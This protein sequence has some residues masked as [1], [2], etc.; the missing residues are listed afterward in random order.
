MENNPQPQFSARY[1]PLKSPVWQACRRD[2]TEPWRSL[3]EKWH[4]KASFCCCSVCRDRRQ[5]WTTSVS[6]LPCVTARPAYLF[7]ESCCLQAVF[8]IC[9]LILEPLPQRLEFVSLFLDVLLMCRVLL[10]QIPPPPHNICANGPM[11]VAFCFESLAE[12]WKKHEHN[13]LTAS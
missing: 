3:F 11:R 5:K 1:K 9:H 2:K 13:S 10:A 12:E 7:D 4:L 6:P 8:A